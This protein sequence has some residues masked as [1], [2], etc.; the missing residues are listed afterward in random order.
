V[1][2]AG[3][4]EFAPCSGRLTF[5]RGLGP[6]SSVAEESDNSDANISDDA[7]NAMVDT[8]EQSDRDWERS[9]FEDQ[10]QDVDPIRASMFH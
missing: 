10:G 3:L 2:L 9:D 4:R 5:D 1:T 6:G 8:G 7:E